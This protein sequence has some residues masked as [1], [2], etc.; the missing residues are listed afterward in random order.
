VPLV[1]KT[2]KQVEERA[3]YRPKILKFSRRLCFGSATLWHTR[4]R[5][6]S[7]L[8]RVIIYGCA[9]STRE[10][11]LESVHF[12]LTHLAVAAPNLRQ[13]II[14]PPTPLPGF[15]LPFLLRE[16][17]QLEELTVCY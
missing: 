1:C 10:D 7:K 11:H 12:L 3:T 5:D 13:L 2:W 17:T 6:T 15:S 9:W 4:P 8:A 16:L 14:T